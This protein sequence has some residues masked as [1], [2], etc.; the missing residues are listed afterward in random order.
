MIE[1]ILPGLWRVGGASWDVG[2]ACLSV[3]GD[4]NVYLLATKGQAALID[5]ATEA[6]MAAIETNI[7]ETGVEPEAVTDLILTHSHCDHS[8][9]TAKWL[10]R[11][12]L[13]TH[14][15]AIGAD[16]AQRGDW[17]LFGYP[18]P[19]REFELF[20]IDHTIEDGVEFS[21][22]GRTFQP[23]FMPGHTPDST[24]LVTEIEGRRVGFCGDV[25]F[26]PDQDGKLGK[27]GWLC[28]K[29][30]SNLADYRESLGKMLAMELDMLLPGHG[31]IL[32]GADSVRDAISA[33][34]NTVEQ[35]IASPLTKHFG[36][37]E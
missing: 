28:V 32:D 30:E 4:S 16:W 13:R 6:G 14:L 17:R 12:S 21:A 23:H 34:L 24:L 18:G 33:S 15:N 9:A 20:R 27:I 1:Q 29:W 35:I 22:A 25:C 3:K 8:A 31:F 37:L 7:R 19:I 26:G 2:A 11:Y 10:E 5:C 36:V